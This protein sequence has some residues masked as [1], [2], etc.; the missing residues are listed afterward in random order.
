MA[1]MRRR[2][3]YLEKLAV[4]KIELSPRTR[5]IKSA[6]T[7]LLLLITPVVLLALPANFF[8]QGESIC[9]SK[10]LFDVSC[11]AC[12]LTKACMHLI[13][14]NFEQ[15]F[16]YNMGSF[17]VFPLFAGLWLYWFLAERKK[18]MRLAQENKQ[19]L[20]RSEV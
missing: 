10:R 7:I 16:Y 9:L 11:Y 2:F 13:H 6:A 19:H 14:L 5:L 20:K 12:G 1:A 3:N 17:I 8:D 15:A 4:L 18:L